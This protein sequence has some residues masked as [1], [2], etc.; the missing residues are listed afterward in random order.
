V[1]DVGDAF[2]VLGEIELAQIAFDELVAAAAAD[3]NR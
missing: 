2:E 3:R 1:E